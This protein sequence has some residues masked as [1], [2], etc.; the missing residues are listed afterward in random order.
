[1]AKH[2]VEVLHL[3]KKDYLVAQMMELGE[4][5]VV[6]VYMDGGI[7]EETCTVLMQHMLALEVIFKTWLPKKEYDTW[8]GKDSRSYDYVV[9]TWE[10]LLWIDTF[11]RP[12]SVTETKTG[13]RTEETKALGLQIAKI[14]LDKIAIA[15]V[16]RLL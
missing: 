2:N 12:T 16:I 11:E 4:L 5:M 13:E 1:M 8:A 7:Q 15:K 10:K 9:E 3:K 6:E 14:T